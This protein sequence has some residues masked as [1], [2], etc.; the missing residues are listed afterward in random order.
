MAGSKLVE[1]GKEKRDVA[2]DILRLLLI[3]FE[4]DVVQ[5]MHA[6]ARH[7]ALQQGC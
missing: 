4:R 2:A 3:V 6:C 5:S 7:V 1:T